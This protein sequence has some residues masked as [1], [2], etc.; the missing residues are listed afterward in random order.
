[1]VVF[2]FRNKELLFTR[3]LRASLKVIFGVGFSRAL[4]FT[5]RFGFGFPFFS[6][7]LNSY[8]ISNLLGLL[9]F[10]LRSDTKIQRAIELR[11]RLLK[12]L[13]H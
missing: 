8:Y 9:N 7:L 10:F 12:E 6:S 1:M 3:E 11:V 2:S 13:G 4:W 5:C